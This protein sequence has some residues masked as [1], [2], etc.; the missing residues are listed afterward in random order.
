MKNIMPLKYKTKGFTLIEVILS[1]AIL[2]ILSV[3]FVTIF[4][5]G[6]ELVSNSAQSTRATQIAAGELENWYSG[7]PYIN[8][9]TTDSIFSLTFPGANILENGKIIIGKDDNGINTLKS[10]G[11]SENFNLTNEVIVSKND[12]TINGHIFS[13]HSSEICTKTYT[14][15]DTKNVLSFEPS[16]IYTNTTPLSSNFTNY[17]YM[18][19]YQEK[20]TL[21]PIAPVAQPY[22]SYNG[23]NKTF[24]LATNN[25]YYYVSD[26]DITQSGTI[27]ITNNTINKRKLFIFI[28][29]SFN[30]RASNRLSISITGIGQAYTSVFFIYCGSLPAML[31]GE[32]DPV[33]EEFNKSLGIT[34]NIIGTYIYSPNADLS[35]FGNNISGVVGLSVKVNGTTWVAPNNT[36]TNKPCWRD[37]IVMLQGS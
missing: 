13:I 23:V 1:I 14:F 25:T 31:D 8:T 29:D 24:N 35:F 26:F 9:T 28:R 32:Y 7:D 21:I 4:G 37:L 3:T 22:V 12:L 27:T 33:T 2:G 17:Y 20:Y 30:I 6:L 36:I 11:I 10:F 18:G 19:T 34:A 16:T 5:T 15:L